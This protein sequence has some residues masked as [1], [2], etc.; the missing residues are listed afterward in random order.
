[1]AHAITEARLLASEVDDWP[2]GAALLRAIEQVARKLDQA[3]AQDV[4]TE[5]GQNALRMTQRA[6]QTA[7]GLAETDENWAVIKQRVKSEALHMDFLAGGVGFRAD[8][9]SLNEWIEKLRRAPAAL[10]NT[11]DALEA[12][13][14]STGSVSNALV[15]EFDEH[16]WIVRRIALNGPDSRYPKFGEA[17]GPLSRRL[18]KAAL[19]LGGEGRLA[20]R[21]IR[22]MCTELEALVDRY[23]PPPMPPPMKG[24]DTGVAVLLHDSEFRPG[25]RDVRCRRQRHS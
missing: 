14:T 23:Y 17:L 13:A 16:S 21:Q 4:L 6:F 3:V 25:Y 15:L 22:E 5:Q 20:A 8:E 12:E 11:L 7:A 24:R 18:R 9:E 2:N 10:R 19:A 1:M